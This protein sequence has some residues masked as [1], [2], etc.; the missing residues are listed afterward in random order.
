MWKAPPPPTRRPASW[1]RSGGVLGCKLQ[2]ANEL[3]LGSNHGRWCLWQG[4]DVGVFGKGM[5]K[6]VNG[7]KQAVAQ[8]P[9]VRSHSGPPFLN[10]VLTVD[11]RDV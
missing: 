4:K 8:W 7:L 6:F 1:F 5:A 9:E 10:P 3:V 11:D 2:H